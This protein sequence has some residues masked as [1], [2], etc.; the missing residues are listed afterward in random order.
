MT[1]T[2]HDDDDDGGLD[3][4]VCCPRWF[5]H[6]SQNPRTPLST[7]KIRQLT[8][9]SSD[10]LDSPPGFLLVERP[11]NEHYCILCIGGVY[12]RV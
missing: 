5:P 9:E 12:C 10:T 8:D 2:M 3:R 6:L 1:I 11:H 7:T 4:D